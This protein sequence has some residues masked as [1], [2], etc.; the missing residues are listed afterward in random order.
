MGANAL[1]RVKNSPGRL[2]DVS[3]G[4][5]VDLSEYYIGDRYDTEVTASG[6]VTANTEELYFETLTNKKEIDANFVEQQRL[7]STDE[8][9][10]VERLWVHYPLAFGDTVVQP[11]D[12]KK[13]AENMYFDWRLYKQLIDEGPAIKYP[14]G[15]G[16]Y[17]STN[18]NNTGILTNGLPSL[19]AQPQLAQGFT[20][21]FGTRVQVKAIWFQRTWD[22]NNMATLAGK[23]W[24]KAGFH[25]VIREAAIKNT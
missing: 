17:G 25:G 24:H 9:M 14:T 8:E 12:I 5:E 15:Y 6:A 20:I 18:E 1:R 23:L 4:E 22:A 2:V 13:G 16:L 7:V 21:G 3:T 19:A 10:E 11:A